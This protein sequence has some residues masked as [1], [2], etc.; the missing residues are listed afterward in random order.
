M[1]LQIPKLVVLRGNSGS[2]KPTVARDLAKTLR[3]VLQAPTA[4][5][6]QDHFRRIVLQEKDKLPN[7]CTDLLLQ[8]ARFAFDHDYHVILEGI[9]TKVNYERLFSELWR[10]HPHEN[11]A[12]YFKVSFEETLRRHASKSNSHEFGEAELRKWWKDDDRLRVAGEQ[13]IDE[14]LSSAAIVQRILHDMNLSA[15]V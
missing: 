10:I 5:L 11:Y 4:L 13:L 2:G 6:E 14:Q 1:T 7:L 12:Y 3:T 9:F 8:N 15:S